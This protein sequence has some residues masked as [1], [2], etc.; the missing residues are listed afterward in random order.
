MNTTAQEIIG[1]WGYD[2]SETTLDV[3]DDNAS[4]AILRYLSK[5]CNYK[6]LD[7]REDG[8]YTVNGENIGH[9][10]IIGNKITDLDLRFNKAKTADFEIEDGVLTFEIDFVELNFFNIKKLKDLD[11][12]NPKDIKIS[13]AKLL[14]HWV[15]QHEDYSYEEDRQLTPTVQ[16][17]PPTIARDDNIEED[18]DDEEETEEEYYPVYPQ[19]LVGKW[20]IINKEPEAITSNKDVS[21]IIT[22][23][24][25]SFM[26]DYDT[27]IQF[28]NDGKYI[29]YLF[30][31]QSRRNAY[32]TNGNRIKIGSS[33]DC[34]YSVS[35]DT[36][37]LNFDYT[38]HYLSDYPK[39]E[40]NSVEIKKV[41]LHTYLKKLPDNFDIAESLR[42]AMI[43]DSI[44]VV[45][46]HPERVK[47]DIIGK[48]KPYKTETI[49]VSNSKESTEGLKKISEDSFSDYK[50]SDLIFGKDYMIE[51]YDSIPYSIEGDMLITEKR[52]ITFSVN[53]NILT[54]EEDLRGALIW[55]GIGIGDHDR[56]LSI[57]KYAA[58]TYYVKITEETYIELKKTP[59]EFETFVKN[60]LQYPPEAIKN[61]KEGIV[62]VVLEI[63]ADGTISE[64]YVNQEIEPLLDAE[65]IRIARLMTPKWWEPAKE[66]NI[67]VSGYTAVPIVF[68][69]PE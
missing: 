47:E 22:D 66:N 60:N 2:S 18:Y 51:R 29:E 10:K 23:E 61:K 5:A 27:Y 28:T 19:D 67:A 55:M 32:N 25:N 57:Q 59:Q 43:R 48:W 63:E 15:R 68:K 1:L 62:W 45:S 26:D 36:L 38:K 64:A 16:F 53:D 69:L 12:K 6:T 46:K 30:D 39:N 52:N 56:M 17:T 31:N 54:T 50:A 4:D 44:I 34:T 35:K 41:E 40:S 8:T 33:T 14:L 49:V 3:N 13:E 11:I 20:K 21:K 58:R 37:K 24:F 42:T 9:Y 7:F 65:A